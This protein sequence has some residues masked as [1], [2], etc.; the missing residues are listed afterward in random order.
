MGLMND[1]GFRL[2]CAHRAPYNY[3][4]TQSLFNGAQIGAMMSTPKQNLDTVTFSGTN[5]VPNPTLQ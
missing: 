4:Q 2:R 1:R 5:H 3:G